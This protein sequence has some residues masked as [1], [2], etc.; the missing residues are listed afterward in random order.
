MASRGFD[1]AGSQ[2]DAGDASAATRELQQVGAHATPDFEQTS[3]REFV[4][5]HCLRHPGRIIVVTMAFDFVKELTRAKLVLAAINGAR[6][7]FAPLFASAL[8][9][10][11]LKHA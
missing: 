5:A 7:I 6:R 9:V 1:R 2:I 8:F 4:E 11:I 10:F 3:P